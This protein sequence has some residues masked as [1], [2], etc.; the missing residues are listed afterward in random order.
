MVSPP[1]APAPRAARPITPVSP[2]QTSTAS[3]WAMPRPSSKASSASDVWGSDSPQTA[4]R[5][6]RELNDESLYLDRPEW[7]NARL[8]KISNTNLSRQVGRHLAID[9][10]QRRIRL[11]NHQGHTWAA[12][13]T[14]PP[15]EGYLAQ[16][17]DIHALGQRLRAAVAENLFALAAMRAD[18]VAHVLD[19]AEVRNFQR[20]EHLD[21]ASDIGRRHILGRRD[22]HRARH[23]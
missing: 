3:R 7:N 1:A 17:W 11:V 13:F 6:R 9:G 20:V 23:R 2:P 19:H 16:E 4:T 22:D 15:V 8:L 5:R 21:R 18:E 14:N 12:A 10:G